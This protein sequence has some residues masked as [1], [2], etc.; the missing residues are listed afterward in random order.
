[1]KLSK[2]QQELYDAILSGV[3]VYYMPYM[4]R[5]GGD[6]Y[7]RADNLKRCTSAAR[8]LGDKKLV[9]RFDESW[10]GHKLR[11]LKKDASQC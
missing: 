2:T 1:M 11:A 6:Y 8:A 3:V 10:R 4:G 7:Y 5:F 9:E